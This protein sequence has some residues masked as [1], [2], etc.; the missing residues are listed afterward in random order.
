MSKK[1]KFNLTKQQMLRMCE[2]A[3]QL[4]DQIKKEENEKKDK[5]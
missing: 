2:L 3:A 4:R 5:P 1:N